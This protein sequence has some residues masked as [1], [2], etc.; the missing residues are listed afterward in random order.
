MY[1][2]VRTYWIGGGRACH[3]W[4][5]VM[6]WNVRTYWIGGG[7]ACHAWR[8]VTRGG[9]PLYVPVLVRYCIPIAVYVLECTYVL[10]WGGGARVTRGGVPPFTYVPV[11][12]SSVPYTSCGICTG[13]GSLFTYVP[14]RTSSVPYTSCGICTGMYVRTGLGGA[15]AETRAKRWG[16]VTRGGVPLYVPV[17]DRYCIHL[18]VYVLEYTYLME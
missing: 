5:R 9:V 2:N 16:R 10:D 1:W 17:L 7:R 8:R 18:A 12:T 3:A 4:R 14:V 15:G 6:Y 11:R 13:M